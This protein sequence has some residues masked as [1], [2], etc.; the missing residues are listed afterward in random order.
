MLRVQFETLLVVEKWLFV[1]ANFIVPY[2]QVES[3]LKIRKL[4]ETFLAPAYP[5]LNVRL[6]LYHSNIVHRL[7]ILG[8]KIQRYPVRFQ[9]Q[10][11][12]SD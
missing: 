6:A 5:F 8:E 3:R 10:L 4:L 9:S 2:R 7:D 12:L 11:P 1:I